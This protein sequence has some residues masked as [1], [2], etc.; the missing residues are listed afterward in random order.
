MSPVII[1]L[2]LMVNLSYDKSA[3]ATAVVIECLIIQGEIASQIVKRLS[4]KCM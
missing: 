1:E 3:Y 4:L 2:N